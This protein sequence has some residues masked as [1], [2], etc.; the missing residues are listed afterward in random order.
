M[1][2]RTLLKSGILAGAGLGLSSSLFAQKNELSLNDPIEFKGN[3]NHSVC[4]WPFN[5]IPFEEFCKLVSEMGL[6]SI[7][8][9][10]PEEWEIM[11]DYGL[12]SAIAWG[13]YPAGINLE[14]FYSEEENHDKL[15]KFYED[16]LPKAKAAGINNIICHSGNLYS[17]SP[18]SVLL[19]C[20]KGIKRIM[21]LAE[22][23]DI[24]ISI[25]VFNTKVNHP[26]QACASTEW[27]VT[28]CEMVGS[29]KF[30]I[31][32]DIYHMQIMEG[33]I[34]ATIKKYNSYISHYHTAGVPGRFM[35]DDTQEVY[36]PAIMNAIVETGYKGYVAQEFLVSHIPTTEEKMDLLKKAII[37][38]DV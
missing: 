2:R 10:G 38:C 25:E 8:L 29:E 21:P 23:L 17:R 24:T 15:T 37:I 9:T 7:D 16:L 19:T 6:K 3:I 11:K 12:T 32:Y 27:A 28:L 13:D 4:R 22:E 36:Y 26:D 18:E 5:D 14:H 31:L 20:Q 33:D 1:K 34:I 30:K 35:I